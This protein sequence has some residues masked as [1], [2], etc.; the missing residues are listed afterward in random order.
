MA[1]SRVAGHAD[2]MSD[3]HVP[4]ER[5]PEGTTAFA[6]PAGWTLALWMVVA[7]LGAFVAAHYLLQRTL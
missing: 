4:R 2:R 3:Q 7:F 5:P 1:R 6:S